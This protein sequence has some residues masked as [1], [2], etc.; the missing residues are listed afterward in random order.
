MT[1]FTPEKI[2]EIRKTTEHQARAAGV[3]VIQAKPPIG[4]GTGT[5]LLMMLKTMGAQ[6]CERCE[7]YARWMNAIGPDACEHKRN[8]IIG[9]LED[10]RRQLGWL[11]QLFMGGKAALHGLPLTVGGLV[12]EA[13]KRARAKG[14]TAP[15]PAHPFPAAAAA[16][17]AGTDIIVGFKHGVGDASN[18][19]HMLALYVR[20]GYKMKVHPGHAD[21]APLFLAAGAQIVDSAP[22]QHAWSEGRGQNKSRFNLNQPPLPHLG[23]PD[24]LWPEYCAVQLDLDGQ[25]TEHDRLSVEEL[26]RGAQRPY[27]CIHSRGYPWSNGGGEKR[28]YDDRAT[29]ELQDRLLT[30]TDGTIIQLDRERNVANRQLPNVRHFHDYGPGQLYQLLQQSDLLIG[31]DSGPLHFCRFTRTPAI[32][33][34]NAHYPTDY[35]LPRPLTT[36][37]VS[38]QHGQ[39]ARTEAHEWNILVG[40]DGP[41]APYLCE[42]ACS[43]LSG[44]RRRPEPLPAWSM[45]ERHPSVI[46]PDAISTV[47]AR[48]REVHATA[49]YDHRPYLHPGDADIA[50]KLSEEFRSGYACLKWAVAKV[51]QPRAICEIGVGGGLAALAFLDACPMAEYM[52]ID[53]GQHQDERGVPL[54]AHLE[55]IFKNRGYNAKIMQRDSRQMFQLP[56]TFDLVHIDGNHEYDY[57]RHDVG[58][59]FAS[60]APWILID[61]ARDNVVCAATFAALLAGR[62][63]STE[64]AMF[65]DTWTGSILV[66]TGPKE[67]P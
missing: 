15:M 16:V 38:Q 64:W 10:E 1:F 19:A 67:R 50:A 66:Y 55:S 18:F 65:E 35:L 56:G 22:V 3:V 14:V 4:Q 20:R 63:G 29:H 51:I 47:A 28:S 17:P 8:E 33:I 31:I 48:I 52:G 26:L 5:E 46:F 37:V 60:G 59:A 2:A 43:I 53:N 6:D 49:S 25:L 27:I 24:L 23:D 45:I 30:R 32:G 57:A 58:V 13:I 7:N 39:R 44:E 34:W 42:L 21:H 41:S 54:I 62:P 11:D 61:D 36:N 40:D 12:D 9:H